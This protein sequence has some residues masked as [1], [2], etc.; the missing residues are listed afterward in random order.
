[1]LQSWLNGHDLDLNMTIN[2]TSERLLRRLLPAIGISLIAAAPSCVDD[3]S[4][5]IPGGSCGP[6]LT[7]VVCA[8]MPGAEGTS[9]GSADGATVGDS[10]GSADTGMT[11]SSSGFE[12]ATDTGDFA[13]TGELASTGDSSGLEPRATGGDGDAPACEGVEVPSSDLC[14]YQISEVFEM[15]GQCCRRYE[16]PAECCDGRPFFVHDEL[17]LAT[18]IT[19][20]DWLA[21][22]SP[23]IEGLEPDE[24]AAVAQAWEADARMEHASIAS[25]ARFALQLMALGA[26]ASLVSEAQQAMA[27]EIEHARVCFGLASAYA[28]RSLG[29]GP[30]AIDGALAGPQTL[31]TIA[32]ATVREGCI[33][34]TLAAYQ[35]EIAAGRAE[36]PM[37]RAALSTIAEDEA[38]HAALAWRTVAWALERGGAEVRQAVVE[39]LER[40]GTTV[41]EDPRGAP[42]DPAIW[43]AHGRLA[44]RELAE[45]MARGLRE[46]VWPCARALLGAELGCGDEPRPS[47]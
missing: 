1:M 11:S 32:A 38:R 42:I 24:R 10:S 17:R 31:A 34:E 16:G 29:P 20:E 27:D 23:A 36:E 35:A 30:L 25:F 14:A 7:Q 18:T 19:R 6:D 43:R 44:P 26:P 2:I 21:S 15:D 37:V 39:A 47:V 8:P 22:C 33:G 28:G 3:G 40:H 4:E 46:V 41:I 5:V 12:S 13:T 45:V 9:S